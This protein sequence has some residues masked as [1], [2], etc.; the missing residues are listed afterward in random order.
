MAVPLNSVLEQMIVITCHLTSDVVRENDDSNVKRGVES[1]CASEKWFKVLTK[2]ITWLSAWHDPERK[3]FLDEQAGAI[4][5]HVMCSFIDVYD[6]F[7]RNR[8]ASTIYRST[9]RRTSESPHKG[10][11]QVPHAVHLFAVRAARCFSDVALRFRELV[12][13]EPLGVVWCCIQK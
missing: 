10:N 11:T 2:L 7:Q 3:T 8:R 5:F 12:Q 1:S 13:M 9:V 4:H 6:F